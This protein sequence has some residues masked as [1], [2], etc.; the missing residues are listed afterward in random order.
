[1]NQTEAK[2]ECSAIWVE[3]FTGSQGMFVAAYDRH[4]DM[5]HVSERA[6]GGYVLITPKENEESSSPHVAA[7]ASSQK[8]HERLL[9]R[10]YACYFA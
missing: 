6:D 10:Y 7:R 8:I 5:S 2:R 3:V 9:Y 1:M 4:D